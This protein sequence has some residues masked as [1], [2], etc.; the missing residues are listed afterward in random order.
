MILPSSCRKL[1]FYHFFD[2]LQFYPFQPDDGIC[3]TASFLGYSLG[4]FMILPFFTN[5]QF[6][7][8]WSIY[9]FTLFSNLR[10]FANLRFHPFCSI[11][12][13]TLLLSYD[14][15]L[16]CKFTILSFL[17]NLRFFLLPS[18]LFLK[19]PEDKICKIIAS[20]FWEPR[21]AQSTYQPFAFLIIF[22]SNNIK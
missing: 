7:P 13:F 18:Y 19:R 17:A 20:F 5:L 1:P 16:F 8:C 12:D 3:Y 11:H 14:S 2:N 10:F 15:A 21:F 4:K 9:N 6:Y 22:F